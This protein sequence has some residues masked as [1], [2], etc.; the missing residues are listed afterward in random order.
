MANQIING[1]ELQKVIREAANLVLSAAG[2]TLGPEGRPVIMSKSFGGPEITKDGYK[3]IRELKPEDE[4]VAKI[5]ELLNQ[6]TSQANE[7]AG[8]GTTTATILVA[9]LIKGAH[10]HI[11]AQRS[12]VK[13][14][15]GIKL[16]RDEIIK[17]IKTISKAISSQE[18][19]AQVGTVSANGNAAIGRKIAEAM[20]KVGKEGVITVEEGKGL[21]EFSVSV[22]Q[23]MVFDRGYVSPYMVTNSEKMLV[24]FDN[25]YIMLANKKI[26]TIQPLV[27]LLE[28]VV[29]SGRP[30]LIIAED[31]EGEALSSL[32]I[33]KIRGSL[34]AAAV[35]APGFGDRR[36]AILEDIKILSGAKHVISDDLGGNFEEL[37]LEDLGTA[38]SVIIT[39]DETTIV[40]GEGDEE[41]IKARVANLKKQIE[42]TTS[43]YDK[44]KLQERLAKLA[45]GVAVL[46]VGGATEVEVKE[47]K[48]RV[49]DALHAT[50]A[51]V[52]E[53]IVAGG[54][55][56]LLYAISALER[57]RG[58]DDD[59]QAGIDIVKEALKAP[60]TKIVENAGENSAVIIHKLLTEGNRSQIFDAKD[61]RYADA[62]QVGIVDPA[63][64]VR[65]A[66]ES[67]ISVA[68]VL[69]TAEALIVD[70]PSKE[71]ANSGGGMGGG[72][73][74]MGGMY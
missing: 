7:K 36:A 15:K 43:D 18:E 21:E 12:R 46:K 31:I 4:K 56:T 60:I 25:P 41:E 14:K 73:G 6:A 52:E 3:V 48:D 20:E 62:F 16:A 33:S 58:E 59:E 39:K 70:L 23:G 5:V 2:V 44:E 19:I 67:A 17:Y 50:R 53:G 45:G 61:L 38:K 10:K 1:E 34:K 49:E 47:R 37:R 27:S 42:D 65:V 63:K 26:S 55:A 51:A 35:K 57:L 72:M 71:E 68:G 32:V 29:R 54:G 40:G 66:L 30:I 11:A 13:L 22:V 8:D 24:E 9:E 28:N 64:V 74:G 69:I